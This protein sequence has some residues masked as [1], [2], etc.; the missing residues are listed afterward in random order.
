MGE[1]GCFVCIWELQ[2]KKWKPQRSD[3][4]REF[5]T[6]FIQGEKLRIDKTK[7]KGLGILGVVNCRKVDTW[8]KLMEDEGYV[9]KV[10]YADSGQCYHQNRSH[11]I[12]LIR[13]REGGTIF[14]KWNLC[15]VFRQEGGGQ[16]VPTVSVLSH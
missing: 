11:L 15:P 8:G 6:I 14:T 12:L 5:Y 2:K 9:S 1:K 7:E 13:E 4:A 16:R 3:Y 10:C